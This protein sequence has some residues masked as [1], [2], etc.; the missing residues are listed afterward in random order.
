[1]T[2]GRKEIPLLRLLLENCLRSCN[3]AVL[4]KHPKKDVDVIF[5]DKINE[6]GSVPKLDTLHRVGRRIRGKN[7]CL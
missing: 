2:L 5:Q 4:R 7:C 3:I 6:I 1:M